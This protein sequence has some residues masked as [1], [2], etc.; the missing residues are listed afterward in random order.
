VVDP[1]ELE[2]VLSR[3]FINIGASEGYS[4][5]EYGCVCFYRDINN[6]IFLVR[7]SIR[8]DHI[9]TVSIITEHETTDNERDFMKYYLEMIVTLLA[10]YPIWSKESSNVPFTSRTEELGVLYNWTL[11]HLTES[12]SF[13]LK[14]FNDD[15]WVIY[16]LFNL[17]SLKGYSKVWKNKDQKQSF[18]L[19]FVSIFSQEHWNFEEV[20]VSIEIDLL[21]LQ[22]MNGMSRL[23][24]DNE[25]GR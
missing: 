21:V 16:F 14:D 11:K 13:L 25:L 2:R 3:E 24:Q 19:G 23:C 4:V 12:I 6:L 10:K 22:S 5:E 15:I 8:I 7:I 18:I 20:L 1:S 9:A 17:N